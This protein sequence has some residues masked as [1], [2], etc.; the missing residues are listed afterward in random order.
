MN[1]TFSDIAWN[2]YVEWYKIDKKIAN[3][4]NELLKDIDRN[5]YEGVGKPEALKHGLTGY[6]SRRI[7]DK[8]RLIYKI[9]ENTIY[10][11]GCKGHYDDL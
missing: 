8:D 7:S 10:I 4:I 11:L 3:K 2:E 6:Y 1:K 5:G 9:I